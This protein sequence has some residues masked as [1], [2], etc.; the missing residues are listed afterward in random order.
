[1]PLHCF[2]CKACG[3][4]VEVKYRQLSETE[5]RSMCRPCYDKY[6]SIDPKP[7]PV[8]EKISEKMSGR[9]IKS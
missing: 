4:A 7:D 1:M 8:E 2:A 5:L 9:D 6:L 3:Y